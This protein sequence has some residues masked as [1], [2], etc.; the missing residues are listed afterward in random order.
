MQIAA[1]YDI[2]SIS[3]DLKMRKPV[4]RLIFDVGRLCGGVFIY[5]ILATSASTPFEC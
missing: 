4:W 1:K 3:S 2:Y 5:N